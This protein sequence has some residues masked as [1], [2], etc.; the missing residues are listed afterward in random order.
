MSRADLAVLW[1]PEVSVDSMD[2]LEEQLN[3]GPGEDTPVVCRPVDD[4]HGLAAFVV[5]AEP[6]T[7]AESFRPDP[8]QGFGSAAV[9]WT[10][11]RRRITSDPERAGRF[12]L[13][14]FLFSVRVFAPPPWRRPLKDWLD[15]E[16]FELQT[17]M[18]G[19]EWSEGYEPLEEPFHFLNLWAIGDPALIDSPE[20]VR[21]RDTAWYQDVVPGF[22]A[23]R[24]HREIYRIAPEA[25]NDG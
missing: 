8:V 14:P 9:E 13:T 12:S 11:Y 22:Q 6:E 3:R 17:T 15:E 10:M 7:E 20:W 21:V 1:L 24:L 18:E 4:D 5:A 2:D 16:H 25:G 23:S 19:I